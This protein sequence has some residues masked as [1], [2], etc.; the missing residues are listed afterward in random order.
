M[1]PLQAGHI[2]PDAGSASALTPEEYT[3]QETRSNGAMK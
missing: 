1:N 3:A 2:F